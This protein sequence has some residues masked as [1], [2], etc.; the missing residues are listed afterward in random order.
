METYAQKDTHLLVIAV[1]KGLSFSLFVLTIMWAAVLLYNVTDLIGGITVIAQTM[2][3]LV[4]DPL[5]QAL[6]IG[7]AFSGLI[8]GVAG[9]GLPVAVAAPLLIVMGFSPV[10]AAAIALVG[11]AWAVT[12]GSLGSSYFVIQQVTG[13]EPQ[14]IGPHM[15]ALFALPI[16]LTGFAVAHIQGGFPSVRRGAVAI[17]LIGGIISLVVWGMASIGA[18]QIATMVGGAFGCG[19]GWMISRTRLLPNEKAEPAIVRPVAGGSQEADHPVGFWVAFLPYTLLFVLSVLFQIS[20]VKSLGRNIVFGLDYPATVTSLGF[21]VE[22][23]TKYAK[24]SLMSHPFPLIMMSLIGAYL[25]YRIIGKWKSGISMTALKRTYNQSFASSVG[26]LTMVMMSLIMIDSGMT[27]LLGRSIAEITGPVFPVL[28]PFIGLL[29]TFMTGSNTNSNVMFGALQMETARALGIGSV[30]IAAGQSIGGSLARAICPA[31]V[32]VGAAVV[33][34]TG[35]DDQVLR[36][37]FLYCL[38][39]VLAVGLQGWVLIHVFSSR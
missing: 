11:H 18:P 30:T 9:F 36:R 19:A 34:L 2:T 10:K 25:I 4:K 39:I 23:E 35:K 6:V 28:S 38:L 15:A 26:V 37:T 16:I 31:K 33:G 20:W 32:L 12:F 8:Q 7:W 29:G 14:V 22:A 17:I 24:I 5:S 21:A 1:S 3:R 13:I 27:E